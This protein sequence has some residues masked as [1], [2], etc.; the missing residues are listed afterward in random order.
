M[1]YESKVFVVNAVSHNTPKLDKRTQEPV[2]DKNGH[3][4]MYRG[5]GQIVAMIDM[6]KMGYDNGWKEL[7]TK[8]IDYYI[9]AED[10]DHDTNT[11]CYGEH[12][13]SGDINAII[14]WLENR[15]KIDD[16]RRLK[17]LLHL[18]KSFNLDDWEDLQIVH[19]GY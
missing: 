13:K 4:I 3:P 19:Y 18:L 7:F 10:G 11:D 17:P 2:L 6:C 5:Y 8:E 15:I 1:G 12:I 14:A 16:Y 9:F